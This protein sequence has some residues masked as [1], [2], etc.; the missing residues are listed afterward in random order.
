MA[1]P[2]PAA[3]SPNETASPESGNAV[4]VK[5]RSHPENDAV[6]H[7]RPL[8]VEFAVPGI[9]T[10]LAIAGGVFFLLHHNNKLGT[11][12]PDEPAEIVEAPPVPQRRPSPAQISPK[13]VTPLLQAPEQTPQPGH[14]ENN[15]P[16]EVKV[17][18]P[19]SLELL[20]TL[21]ALSGYDTLKT[22][23]ADSIEE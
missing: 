18:P 21:S 12:T 22:L 7:K 10:I 4:T 19:D 13:T 15:L 5:L 14:A 16:Q 20:K 23:T 3:E 2:S 6:E 9:F 11:E 8:V 17:A 1:A